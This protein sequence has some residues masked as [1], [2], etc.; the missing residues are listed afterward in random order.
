MLS[1]GRTFYSK[2]AFNAILAL[3]SFHN[4]LTK[5]RISRNARK[6]AGLTYL[7]LEE[8]KALSADN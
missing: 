5:T 3:K 1:L 4:F 8:W 7:F 2:K 6:N